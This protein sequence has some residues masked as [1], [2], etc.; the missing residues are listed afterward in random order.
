MTNTK[1]LRGNEAFCVIVI[2]WRYQEKEDMMMNVFVAKSQQFRFF[3]VQI[4]P[5]STKFTNF[6]LSAYVYVCVYKDVE[7]A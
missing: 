1:S 2:S 7:K 4:F 6:V 3:S 5:F